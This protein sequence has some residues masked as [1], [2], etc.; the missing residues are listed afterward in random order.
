MSTQSTPALMAFYHVNK[1]ED[2]T[3]INVMNYY[4]EKTGEKETKK[5]LHCINKDLKIVKDP[6]S[7]FDK[8]RKDK[9]E[10]IL[11]NWK[12]WKL[13]SKNLDTC[14]KIQRFQVEQLA[15]GESA[16]NIINK[17]CEKI[18]IARNM[19]QTN[20]NME[21]ADSKDENRHIIPLPQTP[22]NEDLEQNYDEGVDDESLNFVLQFCA[23][24]PDD[25]SQNA[26]ESLI[27]KVERIALIVDDFDLEKAFEDYCNE[28]ENI[29]DLCYSDI[30][31][32]RPTSKFTTK[33][34]ESVWEKFISST[35]PEHKLPETWEEIIKEVFKPKNSFVEWIKALQE[36][37]IIS[38]KNENYENLIIKDMIYNILAP[39]VKAF[40]AP[41]NILKSGD[42][43]ENQYNAQFINPILSNTLDILCNV[44]WRILEFS[45]ESSKKR[46]NTNLD[47]IIDKVLSAKRADGLARLWESQEEFFVFELTGS[48]DNDDLTEFHLHDYKLIRTMRDVLNQRIICRLNDGTCNNQDIASFGAL[49]YC[50]E[51]S[52]FWCTM[53]Q[54][55]YCVREFGSFKVPLI[56]ED[57]PIL[58]EAIT[59][60][61]KFFSFIKENTEKQKFFVDPKK[62]LFSK[63]KIHSV[64]PN[65]PTPDRPKKR[66]KK[67]KAS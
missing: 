9:A 64:A 60:C 12:E 19:T 46:R 35:Y 66:S 36:L 57:L 16:T 15:T 52:L 50:T 55:A 8:S 29:F 37:R 22:E 4:Q 38:D 26:T 25:D 49:G 17:N 24:V 33:I 47:P 14:L 67:Q 6:D 27:G 30:M 63:R 48:P 11:H 44:D 45:I 31:D 58:S 62:K 43:E 54:K 51:I 42:L 28:C 7:Q 18:K 2:W 39:F 13:S 21:P 56:W 3:Y 32:L 1:I 40:K 59:T 53:H 20:N 61:L 10:E 23:P 65:P 41:Y 34:P 5:L